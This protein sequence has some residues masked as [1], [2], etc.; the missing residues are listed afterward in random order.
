M[1]FGVARP[2][3]GGHGSAGATALSTS[4]FHAEG[5][6]GPFFD[7]FILVGNPNAVTANVTFTWLCLDGTVVTRTKTI[8]P[9]ARLTVNVE[10]E[11]P[12]LAD[13]AMSTTVTSDVPIV[14]ERAMY[15]PAVWSSAHNSFGLTSVGTRWG[16]AEGKVGLAQDFHTYILLSN[17]N[18]E[19]ASVIVTFLRAA[20]PPIVKTFTVPPTSRFNVH[21][22]S[23]VPELQH[24]EFGTIVEVTNGLPIAVERAMYWNA[25][26]QVWAGGTNAAG[27]RLP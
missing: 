3:E 20:G 19:E 2:W 13:N 27:V 1:Y 17:G 9:N 12:R 14:S 18:E 23:M 15:W 24:E 22:N 26:G 5:A 21:V 7:T 8:G 4:W 11:D 6:T 25:L 10:T 16:L